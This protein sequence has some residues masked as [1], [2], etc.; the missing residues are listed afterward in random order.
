MRE[1]SEIEQAEVYEPPV[2]EEAGGFTE[3]TEGFRGHRWDGWSG[4]HRWG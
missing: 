1:E 4:F 2:L 3:K